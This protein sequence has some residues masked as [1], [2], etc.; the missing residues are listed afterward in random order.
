MLKVG[1]TGGIGCGKSTAVD[2]FRVL[3]I[4][5]I[6]ADQISKDIVKQGS[7]ALDEISNTLGSDLLLKSGEL[8]RPLLKQKI[9][10]SPQTLEQLEA[11]LHPRI[12]AEIESQ[13]LEIAKHNGYSYVIVDIPLLVEKNYQNMFDQIIVVDCLP[14]QQIQRV[15]LRDGLSDLDIKRIM[16]NQATRAERNTAATDVLDNTKDKKN[17]LSQI[18]RLHKALVALS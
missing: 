6:D 3:G 15:S 8:N 14:E 2:A 12:K 16:K 17:L 9:F 13:V 10:S 1:L 11:I 7:E 18:N 4:P 5:I